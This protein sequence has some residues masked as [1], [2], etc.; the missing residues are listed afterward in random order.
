MTFGEYRE[1]AVTEL[2]NAVKLIGKQWMLITVKDGD[3]ANAM[4]ASWGNLGVLWNKNVCTCYI[5]PQRHTYGLIESEERFSIAF[6]PEKYRNALR[7]CG[8]ESGRDGDK[9]KKAGL[10]ADMLDGV[11]VIAEGELILICRKLYCDD[12]KKDNFID[13][14]LLSNYEKND[15]HRFYI[16]E[17]EKAY[18]RL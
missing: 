12:L 13:M 5:R 18:K 10:S 15:F 8:T 4:T 9:L 1:I 7:I 14:A 3:S 11:P 6:L 16:C 17:I 2:D